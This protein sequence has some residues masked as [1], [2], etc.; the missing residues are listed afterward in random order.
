MPRR[1][2]RKSDRASWTAEAMKRALKAVKEKT[3]SVR[4]AAKVFN[5][6]YTT[7]ADRLRNKYPDEK[8]KL[9][10]KTVFTEE[11][12]TELADYILQL[13]NLFYGM[14]PATV[15]RIAYDYATVNN[16]KHSFC[17]EKKICGKDW[18]NGFLKR[19]PQISLRRPEATSLNRILGF[20]RLSVNEFYDNLEKV[21]EKYSFQA[22]RIYNV[23]ET[24]ISC[25]HRSPRIL[26]RKGRKQVGVVTSGER[27]Q[28][29][30]V[31]CCVSA[32]GQYVPP[33]FI[34]KRE[35]MKEGLSRNG[36]VGSIY[37][38][39]KSGWITEE[40][41]IVWLQHFAQSVKSSKDDPTLLILD[42]HS[43]HSSLGAYN[44]CRDNGIIVVSLPPHCSHRLQPLDVTVFSPLKTAFNQ[45]CD[46]HMKSNH[47][48]KIAVDDIA[49]IFAKAYN[50]VCSI[51][52]GVK[53]FA[54]TG[55]YPLDRNVFNEEDFAASSLDA[56]RDHNSTPPPSDSIIKN[57]TTHFNP[58][59]GPSGIVQR[60]SQIPPQITDKA[61]DI[62]SRKKSKLCYRR[63]SS[64]TD[65][66]DVA[67]IM[68]VGD[69]YATDDEDKS[70]KIKNIS[71][72]DLY[73]CPKPRVQRTCK[74]KKQKSEILTSTPFKSEL[75]AKED[76]KLTKQAREVKKNVFGKQKQKKHEMEKQV[77][78]ND[79]ENVC[80]Y[81]EEYGK[82]EVWWRCRNCGSWAHSQC[83]D[84]IKSE[85]FVS[86]IMCV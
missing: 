48:E 81:C 4:Q 70:I 59:P 31:V 14:T 63:K 32:S 34:Y 29:T 38:C 36:P 1:Y 56:P 5:V 2:T 24:G 55:V 30:T 26:A 9:G 80:P 45:E 20:N 10:R 71:L 84:I 23:D 57:S 83:V 74:R 76:R 8:V 86:C 62:M 12:E 3:H 40:L 49:T 50:R 67:E 11:Q 22:S 51:E 65:S 52:K 15:R 75:E 18:L 17:T 69:F 58:I 53:G 64:S 28:T 7:L 44:F 41:F 85:D 78:V 16:L 19:Q 21:F 6:P 35:R 13:S 33:L 72:E 37:R 61:K 82:N 79:D 73:P 27:G 42:N 46:L 47:F 60:C 66:T 77:F 25:V 39:S 43:T 54:V 68:E